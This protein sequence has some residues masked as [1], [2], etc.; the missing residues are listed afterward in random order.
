[1]K[2]VA[3]PPQRHAPY[4]KVFY[5]LKKW[6]YGGVE[7]GTTSFIYETISDRFKF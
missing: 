6:S 7:E 5:C 4:A 2:K 3:P 1:M